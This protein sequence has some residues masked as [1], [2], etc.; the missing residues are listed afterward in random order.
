MSICDVMY[1]SCFQDPASL[2]LNILNGPCCLVFK[3][4]FQSDHF[5]SVG[6]IPTSAGS[7]GKISLSAYEQRTHCSC[8]VIHCDAGAPHCDGCVATAAVTPTLFVFSC[9][10]A[11]P[12]EPVICCRQRATS[13][14]LYLLAS[15]G[16]SE[17]TRAWPGNEGKL[18]NRRK[19]EQ[20]V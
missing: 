4:I 7:G 5:R 3:F 9:V 12:R 16:V 2:F 18:R 15:C 20:R 13:T 11:A 6:V 10:I 19:R 17:E 1:M 14:G 8:T